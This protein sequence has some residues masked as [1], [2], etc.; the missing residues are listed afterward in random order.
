MT[1]RSDQ[2]TESTTG[3]PESTR[4]QRYNFC[5]FAKRMKVSTT[6]NVE[7]YNFFPSPVLSHQIEINS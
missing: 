6:K 3:F 7:K 4:F 5:Q 2:E 1:P